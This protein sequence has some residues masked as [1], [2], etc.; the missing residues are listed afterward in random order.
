MTDNTVGDAT[1]FLLLFFLVAE[2]KNPSPFIRTIFGSHWAFFSLV[3]FSPPLSSRHHHHHQQHQSHAWTANT[4]LSFHPETVRRR[5]GFTVLT[6]FTLNLPSRPHQHHCVPFGVVSFTISVC[7]CGHLCLFVMVL[8]F[9]QKRR[10]I[11]FEKKVSL[12]KGFVWRFWNRKY[13][14]LSPH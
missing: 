8:V 14:L 10:R 12:D 2:K 5:N 6:P 13:P 1:S 4:C 3:F 11:Q 7:I 9:I